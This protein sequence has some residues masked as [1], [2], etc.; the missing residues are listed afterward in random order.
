[1]GRTALPTLVLG[2]GNVSRDNFQA[3]QHAQVSCLA[4]IPAGWVRWLSQ[5]SLQAYQPP[6]LPDSRRSKV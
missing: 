5:V 1:M 3:L 6:A 4:A 2:K